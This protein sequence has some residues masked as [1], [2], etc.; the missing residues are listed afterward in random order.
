MTDPVQHVMPTVER[1]RR[2]TR[3][4]LVWLAMM[5]G[6]L[7]LLNGIWANCWML[8]LYCMIASPQYTPWLHTFRTTLGQARLTSGGVAFGGLGLLCVLFAL[9]RVH[10]AYVR[11]ALAASLLCGVSIVL[12]L[13][14]YWGSWCPIMFRPS[15]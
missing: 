11:L 6:L 9:R 14:F 2:S 4:W 8:G 1:P 13:V 5:C 3:R 15:P 12:A 10:G 7:G